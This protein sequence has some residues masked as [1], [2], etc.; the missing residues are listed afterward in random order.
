MPQDPPTKVPDLKQ[1]VREIMEKQAAQYTWLMRAFETGWPDQ[2]RQP[3][4]IRHPD[5][6]PEEITLLWQEG[7]WDHTVD[8]NMADRTGTLSSDRP[9]DPT[10]P[11]EADTANLPSERYDLDE[12]SA[13]TMIHNRIATT[14]ARPSPSQEAGSGRSDPT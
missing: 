8:V 7:P 11:T 6:S 10:F 12:P 9:H 13:W 3:Q 5:T 2:A 1:A 4:V 14:A